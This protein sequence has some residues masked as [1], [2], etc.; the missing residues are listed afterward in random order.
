MGHLVE[1]LFWAD[2]SNTAPGTLTMKKWKLHRT[3]AKNQKATDFLLTTPL[4]QHFSHKFNVVKRVLESDGC[5]ARMAKN[6]KLIDFAG[7]GLKVYQVTVS[8]N[9]TWAP[10]SMVELLVHLGY[11]SQDTDMT[12]SVNAKAAK[13]KPLEFYWA[14][15]HGKEHT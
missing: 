14:V 5:V 8:S 13:K 12:I 4:T 15:P 1:D 11:L 7:P 10:D 2:L 9:H 6:C 3:T